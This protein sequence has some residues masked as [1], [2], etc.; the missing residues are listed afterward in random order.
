MPVSRGLNISF[1]ISN[2]APS[3]SIGET[4]TRLAEFIDSRDSARKSDLESMNIRLQ[5]LASAVANLK[6]PDVQPMQDRLARIENGVSVFR[7]TDMSVVE[8]RVIRVEKAVAELRLP[9]PDLSVIT[10]RL[11]SIDSFLRSPNDEFRQ[12]HSKMADLDSGAAALLGKLTVIE[13]AVASL[14]RA[15]VDMSPMLA[16]LAAMDAAL[17]GLRNEL[18][19]LPDSGPDLGPVERSLSDIQGAILSIRQTDLSP[20]MN[21]LGQIDGAL[22][23]RPLQDRLSAIEYGIAATHDMLRMRGLDGTA[24]PRAMTETKSRV[25][26]EETRA[27]PVPEIDPPKS[28]P[29]R[30]RR[31]PPPRVADRFE[32]ARRPNDRANLLVS[33]VYGTPDDLDQ[34]VG[35]GPL[36]QKLLNDIGVYYFWQIS[37]WSQ[38]NVD[39]VDEKLEHFRGRISRDDWVEQSR[40]LARMPGAN[41]PPA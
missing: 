18:R 16:R 2:R 3:I 38:E 30:E 39:W 21:A 1:R 40:R 35:V 10:D 15:P 25:Y 19:A 32:G 8:D 12:V 4:E 24:T 5:T 22:N 37:E 13:G 17:S 41:R 27:D 14:D 7:P 28:Q 23:L 34:I 6:F 20:V 26:A 31:N 29:P 9:E 11:R 33:P 36:L